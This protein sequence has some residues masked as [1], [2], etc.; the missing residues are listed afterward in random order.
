MEGIARG[1]LVYK[2]TGSARIL[3]LVSGTGALPV[4]ALALFGG[5]IADRVERK[6]LIQV[7][8]GVTVASALFV[9]VSLTTDTLTWFHLLG[10]GMVS[11]AAMCFMV[12]AR[13]AMIPQ[14]VGIE[15]FG[16]SIALISI[17]FSATSLVAPAIG[18]GC[19]T[20]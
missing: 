20:P 1:F 9:A 14:L 17:A 12:P 6:L 4:L 5:A 8:Q 15:R 19:C 13:Q 3:G 11:A 7:S 18:G 2:M 10:A 16:N